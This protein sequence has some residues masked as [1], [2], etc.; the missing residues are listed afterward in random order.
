MSV[1]DGN[2]GSEFARRL[3]TL[4]REGGNVLVVGP[5]SRSVHASMG[6]R[7]LGETT[8]DRRRL[9]VASGSDPSPEERLPADVSRDPEHLQVLDH[10][11]LMRSAASADPG[12][13]TGPF[14]PTGDRPGSETRQVVEG[15]L[16]DLGATITETI[17]TFEAIGGESGPGELR[18]C[19][20]GLDVLV[21]EYG[22]SAVFGF[23]HLLTERVRRAG[24]L[25][26]YH[27]PVDPD[28]P[29][30]GMLGSL[31]DAVVELRIPNGHP[32]Q[33]WTFD[34]VTSEWLPVTAVAQS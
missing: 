13:A 15:N 29:L 25:A 31:F 28:D 22:R 19:L 1:S 21:A 10:D 20:D 33:R 27:L 12:D 3:T 11:P 9:L 30:V 32:E 6:R 5:V 16:G 8:G 26:H 17:D 7:L 18:L 4:K 24:G 14:D 23:L 2:G 34:G